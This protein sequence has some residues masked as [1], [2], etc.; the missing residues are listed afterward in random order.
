MRLTLQSYFNRTTFLTSN[1]DRKCEKLWTLPANQLCMHR[2]SRWSFVGMKPAA[3]Q[4][5][6]VDWGIIRECGCSRRLG[7]QLPQVEFVGE[8]KLILILGCACRTP[9]HEVGSRG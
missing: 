4:E 1:E 9:F 8:S 3:K 7:D 5:V 2:E 6:F